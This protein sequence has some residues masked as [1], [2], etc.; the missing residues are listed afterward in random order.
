MFIASQSCQ[1]S[2]E[3]DSLSKSKSERCDVKL[4]DFEALIPLH[5]KLTAPA[6]DEWLF[7]HQESGQSLKG[8]VGNNVLSKRKVRVKRG[9]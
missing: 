8:E 1:R 5:Q 6:P 4:S 2:P 9:I 3:N 7:D